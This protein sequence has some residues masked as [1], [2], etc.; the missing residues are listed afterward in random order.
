MVERVDAIAVVLEQALG[1]ARDARVQSLPNVPLVFE[2]VPCTSTSAGASSA[3]SIS[4]PLS[5]RWP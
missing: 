1:R 2:N 4:R 3:A 5:R